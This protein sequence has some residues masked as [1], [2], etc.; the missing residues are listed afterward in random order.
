VVVDEVG[1]VV[2]VVDE[3]VVVEVDELVVV[4][5]LVVV[6]VDSSTGSR[7]PFKRPKGSLAP[8]A[9]LPTRVD[10]LQVGNSTRFCFVV[11]T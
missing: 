3:V 2:V 7:P 5:F 8:E 11:S 4:D 6:V 1:D 10:G 9:G